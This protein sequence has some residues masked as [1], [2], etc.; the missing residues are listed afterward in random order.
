MAVSLKELSKMAEGFEVELSGF[1][2][3]TVFP[4]RLSRPSLLRLAADGEIPN[5]LLAAAGTLFS[6]NILAANGRDGEGMPDTY[7]VME[8]IARA[9]LVSPTLEE[10]E[11]AG[12]HLTDQQL[13]EIYS[14]SQTGVK[15]L[16]SFRKVQADSAADPYGEGLPEK[17][18]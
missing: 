6:S 11:S 12:L 17:A 14:F 9:S 8:R 16:H 4:V 7:R 18:E 13:I 5:T 15:P 3:E 1:D 10:I 2:S